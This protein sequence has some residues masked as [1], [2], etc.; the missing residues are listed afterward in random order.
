MPDRDSPVPNRQPWLHELAIIVDGNATALSQRSGDMVGGTSHGLFVDDRRILSILRLEVGD[1][2]PAFVAQRAS[3][4]VAE[5]ASAARGLGNSGADPTVEVR[6]TRRLESRSGRALTERVAVTSRAEER[7]ETTVRLVVGG[8]GRDIAAVKAGRLHGPP[9]PASVS[10]GAVVL[11]DEWHLT[12]ITLEG[13]GAVVHP[14]ATDGTVTLEATVTVE[15]G[16][17]AYVTL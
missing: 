8:D 4:S 9:T 13:A 10:D 15:P 3:G 14:P 7:V 17:T 6:R 1:E 11:S 12:T 2:T 16:Q 5:F